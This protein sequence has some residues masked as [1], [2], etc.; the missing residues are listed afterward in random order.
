[1][2]FAIL[3]LMV[4]AA[5]AKTDEQIFKSRTMFRRLPNR[6]PAE[7]RGITAVELAI[8]LPVLVLVTLA[9]I[10]ACTMIYLKQSLKIAAYE[11]GR[12]AMVPGADPENLAAQCDLLLSSRNVQGYSVASDPPNPS[13]LD[14]GNFFRISVSAPCVG[15]SFL[16]GWFYEDRLV[17]ESVE[18]MAE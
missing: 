12:V 18:M 15:N 4:T 9:T 11:A 8:C 17:T 1:M 14:R 2:R 3:A 7:R 10:E 5:R 16:G 13:R 6:K